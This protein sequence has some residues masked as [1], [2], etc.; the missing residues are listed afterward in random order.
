MWTV[1]VLVIVHKR[2]LPVAKVTER[3]VEKFRNRAM[4]WQHAITECL[5]MTVSNFSLVMWK[6]VFSNKRLYLLHW[7]FLLATRMWHKQKQWLRS[8]PGKCN[9]CLVDTRDGGCMHSQISMQIFIHNLT[10]ACRFGHLWYLSSSLGGLGFPFL[11]RTEK[12]DLHGRICAW[13]GI[14][15]QMQYIGCK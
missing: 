12:C 8:F 13:N 14:A 15:T 3:E 9:S 5:N 1:G 10:P 2:T 6:L 4:I 7:V 11:E